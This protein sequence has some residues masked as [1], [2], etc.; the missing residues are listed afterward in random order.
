MNPAICKHKSEPEA[1]RGMVSYHMNNYIMTPCLD[2]SYIEYTFINSIHVV[3]I[4]D[5]KYQSKTYEFASD[6]LSN[7]KETYRRFI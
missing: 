1:E 4:L 6:N 5:Q 3:S 7:N 2:N